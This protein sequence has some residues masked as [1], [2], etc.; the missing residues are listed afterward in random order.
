VSLSPSN[1]K[2]F[3]SLTEIN[4]LGRFLEKWRRDGIADIVFRL[5]AGIREIMVQFPVRVKYI[6]LLVNVQIALGAQS[7][8]YWTAL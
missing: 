3:F 1:Y 8:S 6:S 2:E 7:S 4:Y 5:R